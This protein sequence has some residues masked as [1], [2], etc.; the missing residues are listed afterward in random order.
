MRKVDEWSFFS[1]VKQ[2][3]KYAEKSILKIKTSMM[4]KKF[5]CENKITNRLFFAKIIEY[6]K[7]QVVFTY[8][9]EN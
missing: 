3:K 5:S 2:V 4:N 7:Y 1:R 6:R 9:G 8:S